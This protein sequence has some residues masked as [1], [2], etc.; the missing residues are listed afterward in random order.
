MEFT[1]SLVQTVRT[2]SFRQGSDHCL[3]RSSALTSLQRK[4]VSAVNSCHVS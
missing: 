2:F 4:R 1:L 3:S